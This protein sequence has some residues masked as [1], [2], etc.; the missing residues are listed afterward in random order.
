MMSPTEPFEE[1]K[2]RAWESADTKCGSSLYPS[3]KT[4]E[5]LGTRQNQNR[6][7]ICCYGQHVSYRRNQNTEA[8][9]YMVD[10]SLTIVGNSGY[11]SLSR[12]CHRYGKTC[13]FEVMGF[14]GMATVVDFG[15]PWHTAY[16]Y[17]SIAG[18]SQV[19]Y[20]KVSISFLF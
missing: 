19:Y 16:L 15:T 13:G 6:V 12:D 4:L 1:E 10:I 18:M 3:D 20:N 14:A 5:W 17:C 7:N 8:L 2:L 11:E 9:Q